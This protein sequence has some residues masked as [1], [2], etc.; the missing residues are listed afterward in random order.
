MIKIYY[1]YGEPDFYIYGLN[2]IKFMVS[3]LLHLCLIFITFVVG[4]LHL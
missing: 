2:F 4:V 3:N 1:I